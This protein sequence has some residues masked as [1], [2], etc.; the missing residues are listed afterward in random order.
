MLQS[1]IQKCY[2]VEVEVRI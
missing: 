1:D 2:C